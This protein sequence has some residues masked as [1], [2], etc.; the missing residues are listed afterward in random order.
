ETAPG[1]ALLARAVA[2]P[3]RACAAAPGAR[4]AR[5]LALGG[6]LALC[7]LSRPE[8]LVL[9][10]GL[11]L[12]AAHG[13]RSLR[14]PASLVR[15]L[16]PLGLALALVA[17]AHHACTG[18]AAPA[19]AVRKL[20]SSDPYVEPA[21][22]A[23]AVVRSFA[24]LYSQ[25]LLRA[26]GGTPWCWSVPLLGLAGLVARGRRTLV[27][28]LWLGA[29][30]AIGL[31]CLNTTAPFQNF[32]YA[33]PSLLM[34]LAAATLGLGSAARAARARGLHLGRAGLAAY[35]LA[36]V[37]IGAAL[38]ELPRQ[39]DHFARASRNIAE[40]QVAAAARVADRGARLVFVNDAG[41]IPY[42][43]EVPALDGWGLGGY[44]GLPFARASVHG[45]PAVVELVERLPP[46][47]R[48]DLLAIYPGW[49]P[50]LPEIFGRELERIHIEDNVICGADDKVLYA[51]DWSPLGPAP[52][53]SGPDDALDE[54]DVADLVSERSH[55]Y[56]LP[57][58]GGH[59]VAAVLALADGRARWDGGR[60][61]PE[62]ER[63][64]FV[65][66]ADAGAG[67]RVLTLRSDVGSTPERPRRIAVEV[68]RDGRRLARVE[69]ELPPA[70]PGH[71][72]E[73]AVPLDDVRG[74]DA[75]AIESLAAE[76]RSFHAWL[77]AAE[78]P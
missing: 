30:G 18:E 62:G 56:L 43:S 5:Q 2:A 34:L 67:R 3:A 78:V 1:A 57:T 51:A 27:A 71:W 75:I 54:L 47:A 15:A 9:A 35:P 29:A 70:T 63:E 73:L 44:R 60:I 22:R 14:A 52:D 16:A 4:R 25:G 33:V 24:Q 46:E 36:L 12:A 19:G 7:V 76:R 39:V 69:G 23:V 48:P 64:R 49:W 20:V 13:G 58:R 28:A 17:L 21:T 61:V 59:A 6:W 10:L 41:A 11:A 55:G 8:T 40:Q 65:V 32:R 74:G 77:G 37:G 31:A 66:R 50:G 53:A 45:V 26:L 68:S 42:L 38:G 72:L